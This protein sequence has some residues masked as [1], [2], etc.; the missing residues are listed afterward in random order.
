MHLHRN[1]RAVV[2]ALILIAALGDHASAQLPVTQFRAIY[3][4]VAGVGST[5]TVDVLGG[6]PLEE[7]ERL[8]FSHPGISA[9]LMA[10]ETQPITGETQRAFGKFTL[11]IPSDLPPG[12]YEAW[13]VGRHGASY[14]RTLWIPSRPVVT[15]PQPP[16][17]A[18]PYPTLPMDGVVVDRFV[19]ARV[20]RYELPLTA[21]GRVRIV[22]L[23]AKLDSRALSN[24]RVLSPAGR[25]LASARSE[26]RDGVTI[27]LTATDAGNYRIELRDGIYRGGDEFIYALYAEPVDGPR[28]QPTTAPPAD[29]AQLIAAL[30]PAGGQ[31][32][33]ARQMAA[34]PLARWL[35]SEGTF[36]GLPTPRAEPVDV[37]L[38]CIV[39]GSFSNQPTGEA[40]QF[41]A[42]KGE[43]YYL[44]VASH[45]LGENSDAM[46]TVSKVT[47]A[48]G[49]PT[50]AKL[51]EQDDAPP[52]GTAP[53]R[54]VRRDPSLRWEAPEDATYRVSVRDQLATTPA[55]AG[56]Q[57]V[58][59]IRKPQPALDMLA[60]WLYPINNQAQAKPMGNNLL[61]GGSAAIR[62]LISRADGLTGPVEVRCEGLPA[63]IVAPPIMIAADRD[64]GHL[65]ITYPIA[66]DPNA[67]K[68]PAGP[69]P[70]KIK[71]KVLND[72][73]PIE[74]EAASAAVTWENIPSW[75][76][77]IGRLSEQ[78]VLYVNELDT[79]PVTF[80]VGTDQPV[81]M[82][83]GGKLPLPI[84]VA[85]RPG[86]ADKAVLRAQGLPPKV[87]L[88]DVTI[89]GNVNEAKPELVIAA[90]APVGEATLWFQ[91][92]T[93][94]KF[95]NNPQA[96]TRVEATKAALEKIQADPA[97][98]AEKDAVA[99]ALKAATDKIAQLKDPTAE[100]DVAVF[101]PTNSVRIK[102]VE[103]PVEAAA[104]WRIEAKRGTESDHAILVKRLFGLDSPIDVKLDPAIPGVEITAP[105][106]ATGVEQTQAHLKLAADAAPGERKV[107][108][109]LSYKFNNQDLSI[110]IPLTLVISE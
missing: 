28:L 67:P 97:R 70:L 91:V 2:C 107:Q 53:Y 10:G 81:V 9:N 109:K 106:I 96:M 80:N 5:S 31:L 98:A 86:G 24:L 39:A 60:A 7:V 12:F 49:G 101:L 13:A 72:A 22:A 59:A 43:V 46:L 54:L 85:R 48:E 104:A 99:A 74:A 78:L 8:V 45:C 30:N 1:L 33:P 108:M 102:I 93:K 18:G 71:G 95:R 3:P 52:A 27:E 44:D 76:S 57:Y 63:G 42:K 17:D 94:V 87:T 21:G 14:P 56:R 89:E 4:P 47:A 110:A 73:Q 82:A 105:A 19:N 83:R 29:K 11:S 26:G 62:V 58:L 38:P 90:D 84:T 79:L 6:G 35:G 69:V 23:D 103:A 50:I 34:L 77:L 61:P 55:T 36:L 75:N 40:F 16:S 88:A 25:L 41:T 15:A 51:A 37:T 66:A 20:Q 100:K 32:S 65:I 92:E 64:E 68:P